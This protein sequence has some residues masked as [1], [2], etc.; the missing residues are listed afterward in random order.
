ML[1]TYFLHHFLPYSIQEVKD[2]VFS[3]DPNSSLGPDGL[4]GKLYQS[5]WN[6]IAEDI[7]RAVLAFFKGD[8]IPKFMSHTRLIMLPKVDS[9]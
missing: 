8:S 6:V 9:P 3:I 1:T 7:H 4:S 2:C 5:A